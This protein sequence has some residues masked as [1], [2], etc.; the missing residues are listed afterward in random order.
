MIKNEG[1]YSS[2]V[3]IPDSAGIRSDPS[4]RGGWK[5]GH[6][7]LFLAGDY[8]FFYWQVAYLFIKNL[9]EYSFD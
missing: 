8:F 6:L 2:Q 9:N 7:L 1:G 3:T 5:A 4:C